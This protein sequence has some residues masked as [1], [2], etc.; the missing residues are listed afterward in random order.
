M[1]HLVVVVHTGEVLPALV[2][3]DLDQSLSNTTET[4]AKVYSTGTIIQHCIYLCLHVASCP[5]LARL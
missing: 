2:P 5:G 3:S 4:C 1:T